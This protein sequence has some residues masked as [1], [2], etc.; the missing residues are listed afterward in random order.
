M[1]V[2]IIT[3][4]LTCMAKQQPVIIEQPQKKNTSH[5]GQHSGADIIFDILDDKEH[6]SGYD[7]IMNLLK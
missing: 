6:S 3:Q 1:Q 5:K 2:Q 7:F 4:A